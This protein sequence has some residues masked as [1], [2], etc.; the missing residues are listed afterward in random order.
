MAEFEITRAR[1]R[2]GFTPST[3]KSRVFNVPNQ[4]A[5]GQAIGQGLVQLGGQAIQLKKQY[6]VQN[7]NVEFSEYKRKVGL[8]NL[9]RDAEVAAELDPN[10]HAAIYQ[11]HS[12]LQQQFM[13]QSEMGSRAATIWNNGQQVKNATT[14]GAGMIKRSDD[15]WD[16]EAA[17]QLAGLQQTGSEADLIEFQKYVARRQANRP[18][19][20]TVAQGLLAKAGEAQVEGQIAQLQILATAPNQTAKERAVFYDEARKVARKIPDAEKSLAQVRNL[21]LSEESEVNKDK[22]R[23]FEYNVATTSRFLGDLSTDD[24]T[25]NTVRERYPTNSTDDKDKVK[26][27]DSVIEGSTSPKLRDT[28]TG[29]GFKG[30]H[31]TLIDLNKG[32]IDDNEAMAAI[33]KARYT[34]FTISQQTYDWAIKRVDSPYKKDLTEKIDGVLTTKAKAIAAEENNN[35]FDFTQRKQIGNREQKANQDLFD[36]VDAELKNNPD[37]VFTPKELTEMR[38]QI[39]ALDTFKPDADFNTAPKTQADFEQNVADLKSL[40]M[41]QARAYYNKWAGTKW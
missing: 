22:R 13:P 9:E 5:A 20:A 37:K 30:V 40:D 3:A 34:E 26:F 31:D 11:S 27:W 39:G 16:A 6:D 23:R 29:K 17:G 41:E 19:D 25:A 24:L 1:Q 18:M 14:L 12:E 35:R 33:T 38:T 36:W 2:L 7:A 21:N 10:K 4:G 8:D 15:N 28:S 32:T